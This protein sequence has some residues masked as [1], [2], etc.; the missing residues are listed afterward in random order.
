[1]KSGLREGKREPL[2]DT[3]EM[4]NVEEES[5]PLMVANSEEG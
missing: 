4:N 3:N 5:E 1:L 2:I